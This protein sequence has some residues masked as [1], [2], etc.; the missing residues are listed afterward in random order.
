MKKWIIVAAGL[1]ISAVF[2]FL[3]FRGLNPQ[4]VWQNLSGVNP[5]LL[6]A[7]ALWYFLGVALISL[8]WKFLL[9][10]IQAVS[11]RIVMPL[12]CIGYMGNN[13]YPFRSGE[14]LRIFLLQRDTG[15][16][17]ARAATT[18]IIERVFDGI[19]ML[20]FIFV[21]LLFVDIGANTEIQRILTLATPVFVIAVIVFFILAA[22]PAVLRQLVRLVTKPLPDKLKQIIHHLSEEI[23]HGLEGL[24]S[25]ADLAGAVV[26]S[27]ASWMVEASVYWLVAVAFQL[28]INYAVAL[29]MVGVVNLAGL[30]PASPGQFGVYEFFVSLVLVTAT[31]G[32][33]PES[34]ALAYALVIHM[35]IWLPVTL[36]GFG[37]LAREGL[38]W[39]SI[40]HARE[41]ENQRA[42]G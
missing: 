17:I 18:V 32:R 25:P 9:R 12:V 24:R 40:T 31:A 26:S 34:R 6:A 19:V 1:L 21:A 38:G 29:L 8:R 41:L 27:Y 36:V 10:A 16:P 20:S 42:A 7:A 28:E 14:V 15:I 11:L 13:V 30:I 3:A 23:I 2:L 33:I 4:E 35:V 22:R 37:F 5:L 39:H